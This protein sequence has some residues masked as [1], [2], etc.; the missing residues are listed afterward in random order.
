MVI[1]A[2]GSD[3]Y[4]AGNHVERLEAMTI[5]VAVVD[6]GGFAAAARKLKIS[7]PVVTRAVNSLEARMGVRLLARTTRVVRL[8]EVG[9]R[10]A[11]DCRRLLADLAELEEA[12]AGTHQS[13]RGRLVVTAP[14][15]FGRMYI[16]PIV[17]AY[18]RSYPDTEVE[19]RFVDRVVNMMDE[20]VD[21]AI[22]IGV[23]QDS[24][25]QALPVGQVRRVVCA[26]PAYL[27]EHGAPRAPADLRQHALIATTGLTPSPIW[28]F[29]QAGEQVMVQ[30]RPRLMVSSNDDAITAATG[31][32]GIARL[33]SY[34]VARPLAEGALT[35]VLH[36]HDTAILPIH[37]IQHEGRHAAGKVRA[38]LDL[39]T[40]TLRGD[41][42][43]QLQKAGRTRK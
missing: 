33:L 14:A 4:Q 15:M 21:V 32:F 41:A 22:R 10:Y 9:A 27:S 25:Y 38:F 34:M 19:C 6:E 36:G 17:M 42:A 8:T 13:I 30:V 20:G 26:S 2:Q 3:G 40:T 11:D 7:P 39:A 37:V 18:L 5:F 24:S 35:E 12:A 43:L 1:V 28:R 29:D 23:L 16:T 31:G